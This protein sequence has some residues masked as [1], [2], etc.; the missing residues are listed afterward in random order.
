MPN[1]LTKKM[2]SIGL[3]AKDMAHM[4]LSNRKTPKLGKREGNEEE[5]DGKMVSTL[6]FNS[7]KVDSPREVKALQEM[8]LKSGQKS[9]A[10]LFLKGCKYCEMFHP[11]WDAASRVNILMLWVHCDCSEEEMK[12]QCKDLYGEKITFPCLISNGVVHQLVDPDV[13]TSK[14]KSSDILEFALDPNSSSFTTQGRP[15][16]E[17]QAILQLM[18]VDSES[19][20]ES[21]SESESEE[22]ESKETVMSEDDS[23]VRYDHNKVPFTLHPDTLVNEGIEDVCCVLF[24]RKG[25][26]FCDMFV[27]HWEELLFK[28][29]EVVPDADWCAVDTTHHRDF[30]ID[31][32]GEGVPTIL[33]IDPKSKSKADFSGERKPDKILKGLT[34]FLK[35]ARQGLG[36]L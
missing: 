28:G 35:A 2:S 1:S 6:A 33:F 4:I 23:V 29:L 32:G 27:P 9:C 5:R 25:C 12:L 3:K 14:M 18:D 21:S 20:S 24:Y 10:Y 34:G 11:N 13:P 15:H 19:S 36:R 31:M 16:T 7:L 26:H 17:E 8:V 22:S 30:F